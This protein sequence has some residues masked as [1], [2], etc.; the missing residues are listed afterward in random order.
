MKLVSHIACRPWP[1]AVV[2]LLTSIADAGEELYRV[3]VPG[4]N[5]VGYEGVSLDDV[6]GDGVR[7]F[8]IAEP[9]TDF[10]PEPF[11]RIRIFS[12]ATGTLVRTIRGNPTIG[13]IGGTLLDA[14]DVD[15]DGLRDLATSALGGA[16]FFSSANG[17]LLRTVPLPAPRTVL[18]SMTVVGDLNGDSV[19]EVL[20]ADPEWTFHYGGDVI[21]SGT[22][23][24]GFGDLV[25][26]ADGAI[27]RS[28]RPP[29][30]RGFGCGVAALGDV[31]AD[32]V[33]DY[34]IVGASSVAPQPFHVVSGA[35]GERLQRLDVGAGARMRTGQVAQIAD[36][37]G[38]GRRDLVV[39]DYREVRAFSTATWATL[40]SHEQQI[41]VEYA[42]LPPTPVAAVGDV[43]GDGLEDVAIAV[44][45]EP[46]GV[47]SG[48]LL[49]VLSGADGGVLSTFTLGSRPLS[50]GAL[51]DVNGDG[52]PEAWVGF[53]GHVEVFSLLEQ[54]TA[55]LT[56]C[57]GWAQLTTLGSTSVSTNQLTFN[58]QGAGGGQRVVLLVAPE[59]EL[60]LIW[61][62]GNPTVCLGGPLRRVAGGTTDAQ[63]RW[64]ATP[65]LAQIVPGGVQ[66][67]SSWSFQAF[68]PGFNGRPYWSTNAV[69]VPFQP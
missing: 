69:R 32:G 47:L 17:A 50:I 4:T 9:R 6:D 42:P 60:R 34:G 8:A 63:G 49:R 29:V 52:V 19:P 22:L 51:G 65:D 40:F 31:D 25:S 35:S 10:V 46:E 45:R 56:Y 61:Y 54:L 3:N 64:Q 18:W 12:G 24:P 43:D 20:S 5:P 11:G 1:V 67:G 55:P 57:D 2:L 28:M 36:L 62:Q 37:D 68:F 13:I 53:A 44:T 14:G 26:G 39:S 33:D 30:G 21:V 48:G 38:D 66:P 7:D 59:R 58:L 41:V 15:G 27:L 16:A 23:G